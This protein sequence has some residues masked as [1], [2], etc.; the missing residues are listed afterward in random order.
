MPDSDGPTPAV[1]IADDDS[2]VRMVLRMAVENLGYEAVDASSSDAL[3][4]ELADRRFA[5]CLM[6]ASMPTTSLEDRLVLLETIAPAMRVIVMSGY[7][8]QPD[9]VRARGLPFM[10]K[11][12]SLD[13]LT[14][15]LTEVNRALGAGSP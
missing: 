14:E 5:L 13:E 8:D 11:P 3:T 15:A 1:L 4:A 12:I 6:D 7:T 2:L 10:R 9:G